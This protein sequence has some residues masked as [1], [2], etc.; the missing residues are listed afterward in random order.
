MIRGGP[1]GCPHPLAAL[2]AVLLVLAGCAAGAPPDAGGADPGRR[3]ALVV[4]L[5]VDQMRPDLLDHYDPLFTGGLRR[6]RDR[7]LHHTQATHEHAN[8]ETA[9]GHATLSTGV[10]PTRHGVVANSW[11]EEVSEGEWR[12]VYGV[13]DTLTAIV[14]YPGLPGRSP[15]LMYRD[16]LADWLVSHSPTSR[17]VSLSG[18]DRGAIPMGGRGA[19]ATRPEVYWL[20]VEEG[21]FVT[22]TWY[23]EAY[24]EWV[25][26]FNRERM[27]ELFGD[28]VWESSIPDRARAYLR[29]G[30]AFP[31]EGDGVHTIFPHRSSHRTGSEP[32]RVRQNLWRERTP[33][34][35]RATLEFAREAITA[36]ELGQ[37]EVVDLLA[38]SLSAFDWVGHNF[39]PW[40]HEQLDNLLRLDRELGLFFDH[41]DRSVGADRWLLGFTSDHGILEIPETMEMLGLGL[42]RRTERAVER[43]VA[44]RV[45]EIIEADGS[46]EEIATRAAS[47]LESVDWIAAAMPLHT[48]EAGIPSDSFGDLYRNSFSRSRVDGPYHAAGVI[49][50]RTPAT[51]TDR[52]RGTTHLSGYIYDRWVPLTLMGPGIAPGASDRRVATV[53][54]APTLATR[55][56][57]RV[58]ADLDGTSLLD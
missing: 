51:I 12:E 28:T 25:S 46:R 4:L 23:R 24:P 44:R 27:P 2:T 57:I 14:G 41:L 47:L 18:K 32:E 15:R 45:D 34:P 58:P 53:D 52:P 13:E 54:L 33:A 20:L 50:R 36:L 5:I 9:V 35:D 8:T 3:P 11:Y 31:L 6:I 26:R 1:P 38:V 39:G 42:G 17:V 10:H 40:S 19:G 16:G 48:L 29:R 37:R 21:Q 43:E 22:S 55:A 30:D 7:G 49:T 56:G